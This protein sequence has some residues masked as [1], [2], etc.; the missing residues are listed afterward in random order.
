M[1]IHQITVP[2]GTIFQRKIQGQY[3]LHKLIY[4][5]FENIRTAA[6]EL[7]GT[8]QSGFVWRNI[9]CK[10]QDYQ[11]LVYSDRPIAPT[12]DVEVK[13]R[14]MDEHFLQHKHYKFE[15]MI[16][17]TEKVHDPTRK[18]TGKKNGTYRALIKVDD[19]KQWLEKRTKQWGFDFMFVQVGVVR[20]HHIQEHKKSLKLVTAEISGV[21]TITDQEKFKKSVLNGIGR[22]RTFGCGLLQILPI[23]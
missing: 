13:T 9:D 1:Y 2:K 17:P 23:Q 6:E 3:S 18:S 8:K 7:N 16:N 22:G 14:I 20:T 12:A 19:I 11:M 4:S 21:I 5:Q 15:V 10:S